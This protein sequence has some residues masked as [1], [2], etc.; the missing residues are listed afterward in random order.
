MARY[1]DEA[2]QMLMRQGREAFFPGGDP[3]EE[4]PF[5]DQFIKV[6]WVAGWE[7]AAKDYEKSENRRKQ[8]EYARQCEIID[9]ESFSDDCPWYNSNDRGCKVTGG[10]CKLDNCGLWYL[11]NYTGE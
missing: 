7:I 9:F 5:E 2:T 1:K 8:K 4:C 10:H 6:D 3:E 11:K